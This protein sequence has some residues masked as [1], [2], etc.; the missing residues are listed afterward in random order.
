MDTLKNIIQRCHIR[1]KE[2]D[3]IRQRQTVFTPQLN[4]VRPYH[5]KV[6]C[7]RGTRI[8]L[9]DL[10][11]ADISFMPIGHAPHNDRG[12]FNFGGERFSKRQGVRDWHKKSLNASW[13]I[14]IYTGTPSEQNDAAWHDIYITY[15]AIC[16]APDAIYNCIEALIKTT[17]AP[18]L[19]LTKSGGV[20]FSF[21]ITDYLHPATDSAKNY[22]Y[23]YTPTETDSRHRDIYLQIRG[24]RGSSR[25]DGRYDILTGNLL[26]PPVITKEI[27]F[28]PIDALREQ[29]HAPAP[30]PYPETHPEN[31]RP[32]PASLGSEE[33]NLAKAALLKRG[34]AY[35]QKENNVHYWIK[36]VDDRKRLLLSLWEDRE[37][38]W[39]RAAL[40]N[41]EFPTTATPITDVLNDTRITPTKLVDGG[42]INDTIAAIREGNLSPLA[43]KRP[44]P[45]LH[46]EDVPKAVPQSTAEK[47][48][49][50]SD[51]FNRKTH[52]LGLV[53]DTIPCTDPAVQSYIQQETPV[54]INIA[55]TALIES[56]EK[57]YRALKVPSVMRWKPRE[58]RWEQ[59]KA[60]PIEERMATPFAHGNM[61]EDADRCRAVEQ[62]GGDAREV[63]CA[64]CPVL[65]ACKQRGY[66]SQQTPFRS[67]TVQMLPNTQYF[68]DPRNGALHN[69]E[70]NERIYILYQQR[71]DINTLFLERRLPKSLLE[72]WVENWSGDTLGNFAKALLNALNTESLPNGNGIGQVRSVIQAFKPHADALI[73]QMCYINVRNLAG[74]NAIDAPMRLEEMIAA[75]TLETETVQDIEAFPTVCRDPEWSYW[76]ELQYFFDHYKR[77]VD[78][79]MRWSD[80]K[81]LYWL[82]PIVHP[83]IK[84]LLLIG[85]TLSQQ[86]LSKVFPTEKIDVLHTEPRPW[87]PGNQVFQIRTDMTSVDALYSYDTIWDDIGAS[88]FGERIFTGIRAEIERDTTV[89]HVIITNGSIARR[90]IDLKEKENVCDVLLF[91]S[92][93]GC[94]VN[95]EAAQVVWI[96]GKPIWAQHAIWCSAQM[97][98]GN[99]QVPINY[100][101]DM[102]TGNFTDER[103]QSLHQH[104]IAALLTQIVGQIGL[105]R[106]TGKKVVLL[107]ETPLS[108]ITDRPETRLFD[109]EDFEIA[110]G[111][112]K[113]PEFI[114][115]RERFEAERDT[116]TAESSRE[117]V[118]RVYG[119]SS[120][121]ANRVLTKLRGGNIP[122]I[123]LREQI[124][125]LLSTG[126]KSTAAF[127]AAMDSSSQS[128]ANELKRLIDIGEIIRVRRGIYSLTD[129]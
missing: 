97:L 39:V 124:L 42:P 21:R 90:L 92:L 79:P 121:Q 85:P 114:S 89:K 78:V 9:D 2:R 62:K 51:I 38:V 16:A 53:A 108:N 50:L 44:V 122:R 70:Q 112:T 101:T 91:K 100:E 82:P 36:N 8:L 123:S 14:Q 11:R 84:H 17:A 30:E 83:A 73:K 60:V 31:S 107:T 99:D 25:W 74:A 40:P 23:K 110:G 88:K 55:D 43:I 113:L 104:Q 41:T 15:Q 5:Y 96:I 1:H 111:L 29:L 116:L 56:E 49:K 68:I 64:K 10:E 126:E 76:H 69:I 77:D 127:V 71:V 46:L 52:I 57:R 22:I 118:E 28:A 109:W 24:D 20:R 18:L 12:P 26:T 117:E 61:C 93:H 81:L 37:V 94:A 115:T 119:C 129:Q 54:C 33:M 48:A 58:Y 35:L 125:F 32:A 106:D 98:F 63:I 34:F 13:G 75:G 45:V 95:L 19:V 4:Q 65:K 105:D 120:R 6:Q 102:R 27:V 66:L 128:I 3:R 80:T 72:Q 7:A 47:N 59:V 87:L 86:Y 67:A 103:I